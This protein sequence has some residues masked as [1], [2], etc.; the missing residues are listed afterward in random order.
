MSVRARLLQGDLEARCPFLSTKRFLRAVTNVPNRD[1]DDVMNANSG[2]GRI[3]I[4][5]IPKCAA[6]GKVLNATLLPSAVSRQDVAQFI[7]TT[8][9]ASPICDL[10]WK[11]DQPKQLMLCD[12]C[13]LVF[14]CNRVC[15][16]ADWARHKRRCCAD[17]PI[18]DDGPNCLILATQ[19]QRKAYEDFRRGEETTFYNT[20]SHRE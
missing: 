5:N 10:C 17:N 15:Q 12:R 6:D 2:Q 8:R 13:C 4:V 19:Y 16:K 18:A 14:Y 11:K 20:H 3:A 9:W 1:V 7:A